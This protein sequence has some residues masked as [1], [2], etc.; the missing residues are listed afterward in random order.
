MCDYFDKNGK[1]LDKEPKSL[2][3]YVPR[4]Y[5]QTLGVI[6][7]LMFFHKDTTPR[8]DTDPLM[9]DSDWE[10]IE[11]ELTEKSTRRIFEYL[12]P[13]VKFTFPVVARPTVDVKY[14]GMYIDDDNDEVVEEYFD[15]DSE[16]TYNGRRCYVKNRKLLKSLFQEVH[17]KHFLPGWRNIEPLVW[18]PPSLLPKDIPEGEDEYLVYDGQE[19]IELEG[20]IDKATCLFHGTPIFATTPEAAWQIL[21][22]FDMDVFLQAN[23]KYLGVLT[24]NKLD[25]A[26]EEK[27][28]NWAPE[29]AL[30]TDPVIQLSKLVPEHILDL[31]YRDA[32]RLAL[33]IWLQQEKPEV[34]TGQ[35]YLDVV[36]Y[37]EHIKNE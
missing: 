14:I 4:I 33:Y 18:Q 22:V 20:K 9:F 31:A 27:V 16:A 12:F 10:Y 28:L 8:D 19:L 5:M 23:E 2:D 36:H 3:D 24:N 30:D 21:E 25:A 26:T 32:R 6:H 37:H 35:T 7:H 17:P 11:V 34:K 15:V 13:G 1:L 29:K